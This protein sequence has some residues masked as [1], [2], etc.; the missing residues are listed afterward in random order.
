MDR[1]LELAVATLAVDCPGKDRL[2][3]IGRRPTGTLVI[4]RI[5]GAE[6]FNISEQILLR[7]RSF[8]VCDG[9]IEGESLGRSRC[10][11]NYERCVCHSANDRSKEV[12]LQC[13]SASDSF[14]QLNLVDV[15]IQLVVKGLCEVYFSWKTSLS[16]QQL[17][18]LR[19][20]FTVQSHVVDDSESNKHR[21][22][23]VVWPIL[24]LR[25]LS[26][27]DGHEPLVECEDSLDVSLTHTAS[28]GD[29]SKTHHLDIFVSVA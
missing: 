25:L 17:L 16:V 19:P 12:L 21:P 22:S 24:A 9:L 23:V 18:I 5:K 8:E 7:F 1:Q 20:I 15:P 13:L 3:L 11:Y 26:L 29:L 10:P 4:V 6:Y 2:N 28:G 14:G 27:V